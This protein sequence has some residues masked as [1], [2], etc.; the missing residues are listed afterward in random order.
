MLRTAVHRA[1][2]ILPALTYC[3]FQ[4]FFVCDVDE[5]LVCM[6]D[7]N[8]SANRAFFAFIAFVILLTPTTSTS[9]LLYQVC[10]PSCGIRAYHMF[11]MSL[12]V[13]TGRMHVM[14][15]E[16]CGDVFALGM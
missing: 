3:F 8:Y 14:W 9:V 10:M 4:F 5:T 11:C 2:E 7:V 15:H 13:V 1:N 16:W 6:N 12:Q